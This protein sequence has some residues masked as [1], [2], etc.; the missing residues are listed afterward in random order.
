MSL[1]SGKE[2]LVLASQSKARQMLLAKAGIAFESDPADIDERAVEASY[3]PSGAGKSLF[4]LEPA[5]AALCH[6]RRS[7]PGI[8][9]AHLQQ[10]SGQGTGSRPVARPCG[11]STRTYC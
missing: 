5:A 9:I 1:W 6:R 10:A 11:P 4:R 3:V 2:P 8:G 7:D